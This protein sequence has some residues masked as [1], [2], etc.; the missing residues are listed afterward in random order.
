MSSW[1]SL[2]YLFFHESCRFCTSPFICST[3][4]EPPF[5]LIRQFSNLSHVQ[6]LFLFELKNSLMETQ[7]QIHTAVWSSVVIT[8]LYETW[9]LSP[10]LSFF[11]ILLL[12]HVGDHE[13]QFVPRPF[14]HSPC[15]MFDCAVRRRV[16]EEKLRL[17]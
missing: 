3:S 14:I 6:E 12:S 15:E 7:R 17:W 1:K 10:F 11:S 13:K 8:Q 4:A 5:C 2:I 9:P 16:S